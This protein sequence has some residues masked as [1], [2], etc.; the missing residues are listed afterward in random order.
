LSG[1]LILVT[2]SFFICYQDI[3]KRKISNRIVLCVLVVASVLFFYQ[4]NYAVLPY[5]LLIL[6]V[7]FILFQFNMIAAG[8][9][10]LLTAFSLA[11]TPEI[12]SLTIVVI[13]FLGGGVAILYYLFG[14][15]TDL[16]KVKKKG[17]PY[18]LPICM[19]CLFSIAVS[20]SS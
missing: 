16:Q 7:G 12:I 4:Q 20:L 13:G 18:G 1:W 14:L 2:L 17:V 10:K 8:D 19:G 5:S 15:L 6:C 9:I 11:I 3:T